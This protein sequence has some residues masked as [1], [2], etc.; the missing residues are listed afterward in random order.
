MDAYPRHGRITLTDH[1]PLVNIASWMLLCVSLLFTSFQLVS[2]SL[3]RKTVAK[4]DYANVAATLFAGAQVIAMSCAISGGSGEHQTVM[5]D[6]DLLA[7]QK[8]LGHGSCP[9]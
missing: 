8:V 9:F 1:G 3:L 7:Y 6:A 2:N 5:T 4:V